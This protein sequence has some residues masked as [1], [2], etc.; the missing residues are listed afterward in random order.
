VKLAYLVDTD[1]VIHYLNG[2]PLVVAKLQ[3]LQQRGIAISIIS[4]A[5]LYEGVYYSRDPDAKEQD[6]NNFIRGLSIVGIDEEICKV[7]G[8]VRGQ[9]RAKKKTVADFDLLIGSTALRHDMTVLTNNRRHF[10]LIEGLDVESVAIPSR[11]RSH[12]PS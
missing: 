6:L 8:R 5:E 2:Q 1:W 4:L 12:P 7:F 11:R 3:E 9:L 10:E